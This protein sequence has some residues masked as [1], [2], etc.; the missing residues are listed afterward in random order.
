MRED[1]ARSLEI[2]AL[3]QEDQHQLIVGDVGDRTFNGTAPELH[4]IYCI[5]LGR[6]QIQTTVVPIEFMQW[7]TVTKQ[8]INPR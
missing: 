4:P 8:H 7:S 1:E 5:G 3:T 2:H 6:N